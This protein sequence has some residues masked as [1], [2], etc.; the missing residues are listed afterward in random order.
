MWTFSYWRN[1]H[2]IWVEC[3]GPMSPTISELYLH[4]ERVLKMR[5]TKFIKE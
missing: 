1:C 4:V 2:G 5:E 3:Y